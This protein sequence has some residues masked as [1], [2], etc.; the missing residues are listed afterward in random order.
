MF[1][2]AVALLVVAAAGQAQTVRI[3]GTVVDERQSPVSGATVRLTGD[4]SS[5]TSANGRF[6][7]ATAIPGHYVIAVTAIG[8]QLRTI[9]V[10]IVRDTNLTIVLNRRA[11]S[12]DTMLIRPKY[13]Q[14]K[15]RVVD[16][17]SGDFLLQA[18]AT[19][20]PGNLSIGATSGVFVFDSVPTGSTTIVVEAFEH[21]PRRIE[22]DLTRDTILQVQLGIDSVA[23]R[24]T[25]MQVKRLEQ[26]SR[27]VPMPTTALNRDAVKREEAAN[28][29]ELLMRRIYSDPYAVRKSFGNPQDATCYFVDDTK[30]GLSLLEGMQPELVERIEIY[31][32]AGPPAP[33]FK[34]ASGTNKGTAKMVRIYTKRYVSTLPRQQ[35]LPSI[36]FMTGLGTAC[37]R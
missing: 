9:D 17:A 29:F 2:R 18:Q 6:E 35:T 13:A 11:I 1:L 25:A 31:R 14:V 7:F 30:V 24:M 19:V 3:S 20:F 10:S 28:L 4:A 22:L 15:G 27:S 21:L 32:S 26:R 5:T 8:Y 33:S 34:G 12:L 23:L 36:M 16:S 37:P